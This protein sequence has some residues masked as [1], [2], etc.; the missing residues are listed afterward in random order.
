M[1]GSSSSKTSKPSRTQ[2]S[3]AESSRTQSSRARST[4]AESTP[5]IAADLSYA[6]AHTALELAIAEL[7]SPALPV[8]AMAELYQRA[9]AYAARCE[10]VLQQVEHTIELW[11]PQDP[12]RSPT[13]YT[14]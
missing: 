5:S 8:E 3:R 13:T 2:T 1:A 4:Q 7:Q 11:D 12:D 6:E 9:Q 14:P 10:Q